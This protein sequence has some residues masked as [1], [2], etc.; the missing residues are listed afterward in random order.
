MNLIQNMCAEI[1]V[2]PLR[3]NRTLA[4]NKIVD[5]DSRFKKKDHSD[6]VA[7]SPLGADPTTIFHSRLNT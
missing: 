2:K 3:Y 6:V 4:G 1:T 7:A 5:Q